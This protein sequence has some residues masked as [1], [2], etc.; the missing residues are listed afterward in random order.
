MKLKKAETDAVE[1]MSVF[2]PKDDRAL[3]LLVT[4]F[5]TD[6]VIDWDSILLHLVPKGKTI[7][8]LQDRLYFLTTQD[9]SVLYELP[10]SFVEGTTLE[11]P[12]SAKQQDFIYTALDS[13]FRSFT[14][15]DVRQPR[16]QQHLN[17]GETA[18]VGVSALLQ[19]LQLSATDVF[20]DI[21][22][23][24]GSLLA[25][26]ALEAPVLRAIG[27][28]IRSDLAEKSRAAIENASDRFTKL[29]IITII[30]G[31]VKALPSDA[32]TQIRTGTVLFSNNLAFLAED[33]LGLQELICSSFCLRA[34]ALT[35][36]ICARCSRTCTNEFCQ[37][38]EHKQVLSVETCWR[39]KP[40]EVYIY[41]RRPTIDA[42]L[43]LL[44]DQLKIISAY[45]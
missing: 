37:I 19:E 33:V 24:T 16:G 27:L 30:A 14:K 23:G 40:I 6:D 36:K 12:Y 39:Q 13:I 32:K 34:V 3:L 15:A 17:V 1:E 11:A 41:R 21:G 8:E 10:E 43:M 22:S 31:D 5:Q 9:K 45:I 20:I 42:G 44:I 7:E 26:V 29:Q 4:A 25:Q 18:P 2:T 28:E 35:Q 38:W